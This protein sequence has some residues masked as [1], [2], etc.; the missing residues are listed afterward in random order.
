MEPICPESIF[1]MSSL[2]KHGP[3]D[4][5]TMMDKAIT[6]KAAIKNSADFKRHR[7]YGFVLDLSQRRGLSMKLHRRVAAISAQ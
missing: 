2:A 6:N 1:R 4:N 7:V 3:T 5:H